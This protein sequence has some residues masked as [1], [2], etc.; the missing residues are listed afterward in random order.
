MLPI[1]KD[2]FGFTEAQM[3]EVES[4]SDHPRAQAAAILLIFFFN[5]SDL[6]TECTFLQDVPGNEELTSQLIKGM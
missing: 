2:R 6:N 3:K 4:Y 5:Y 1:L